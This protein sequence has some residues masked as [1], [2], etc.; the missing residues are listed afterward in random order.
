MDDI[1]V[2]SR[3]LDEHTE[4]I[5]KLLQSLLDNK[6]Y[7]NPKKTKLFCSEIRFLGHQISA[8]GIKA[9]KIKQTESRTGQPPPA[10]SMYVPF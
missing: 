4:N 7:L 9:E 1:A 10:Q 5:T 8:K 6:L 3:S 2:W